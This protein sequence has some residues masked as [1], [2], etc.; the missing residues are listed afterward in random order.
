M[1]SSLLIGKQGRYFIAQATIVDFGLSLG[2]LNHEVKML[3]E[4]LILK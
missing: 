4:T 2:I 3:S 1:G